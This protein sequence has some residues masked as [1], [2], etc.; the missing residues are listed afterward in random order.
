MLPNKDLDKNGLLYHPPPIWITYIFI[1]FY[2]I[3][4]DKLQ[5]TSRVKIVC[6]PGSTGYQ[7]KFSFNCTMG[8]EGRGIS[9]FHRNRRI[10]ILYMD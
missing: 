8:G 6:K 9:D 4:C 10:S 2:N 5:N 3:S 7:K 1:Q